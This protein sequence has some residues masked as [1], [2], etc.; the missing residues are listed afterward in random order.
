MRLDKFI[1]ANMEAILK[2]WEDFARANQPS[3]GDLK[4]IDL[5]DHAKEMLNNIVRDMKTAQTE[6]ERESKSQ[7]NSPGSHSDTAAEVHADERLGAGFSISLLV[8]E[9][10]A[11]RASVLRL[12]FKG[13]A[14]HR[15]EDA[16]ELEDLIRFNEAIDQALA[17]SVARYSEA[18]I[19][20]S[21]IFVGML[22]HDLRS[23]LQVLSFG[24][25]KLK[26]MEDADNSLNQL[27]ST[28]I[29]SVQRM[30]QML[31]NLMD[32]T[33]SRIGE[34]LTIHLGPTDLAEIARQL[35][36]EFRSSHHDHSFRQLDT[37]NCVGNWDASRVGQI[38]QNLISNAL[39]HGAPEGEIVVSCEGLDDKVILTVKSE[40]DP[41]PESRQQ[42]IFEL[43]KRKHLEKGNPNKNLGLG[44]YIVKDLVMA[45]NGS[46]HVE[47]TQSAGT[48]FTVV[49]PKANVASLEEQ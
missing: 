34:G 5:R 16:N 14:A 49:L 30:K 1:S 11:L 45:H 12:W 43:S 48:T 35:I 29:A 33:E 32:F 38:C 8:A 20:N 2:E 42:N 24:A 36:D 9:Y 19:E 22:G 18:V 26:H 27:G 40:G 21:D 39:Q 4:V 28:M 31:D 37:G 25:A 44:L 13:E 6:L 15:Q 47:S 41:I 23:P 7:G 46:V 17:E 3:G 10:R